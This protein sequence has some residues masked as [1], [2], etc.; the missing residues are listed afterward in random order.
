MPIRERDFQA[1]VIAIAKHHGWMVFHPLPAQ[2]GRGQWRT[3]TQGDT[4]FP[5]L[6]LVHKKAGI[7]FAELK[8]A[9]GKLS[10]RQQRWINTIIEA[11]GEAYV[12]R[13]S[14]LEQIKAILDTKRGNK[15]SPTNQ[16]R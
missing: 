7:I 16:P 6:V 15:W 9:I 11:G 4:G 3:A 1:V 12:W 10:D 13:P 14:D 2:N 8:S 5:D